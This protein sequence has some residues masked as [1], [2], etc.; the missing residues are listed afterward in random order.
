[1]GKK[2]FTRQRSAIY[3]DYS[4]LGTISIDEL[5]QAV[6]TDVKALKDIY[7]VNY[8]TGPRLKIPV[9]NEYGDEVVVSRP[10]GGGYV[11]RMDTHH[12]RPACK[13]YDL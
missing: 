13:D 8:V 7:H 12:Y 10:G 5:A 11:S 6:Y 3:I 9:T 1:M 2:H 4:Q